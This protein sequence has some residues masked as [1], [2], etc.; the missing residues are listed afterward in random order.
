MF[1]F[2]CLTLFPPFFC[3]NAVVVMSRLLSLCS[4]RRS[5]GRLTRC[6]ECIDKECDDCGTEGMMEVRLAL[7]ISHAASFS[8]SRDSLDSLSQLNK[9]TKCDEEGGYDGDVKKMKSRALA[10]TSCLIRW[11]MD[12]FHSDLLQLLNNQSNIRYTQCSAV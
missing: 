8:S 2:D 6:V 4:Q 9:F 11:G 10:L 3:G 5:C 12:L 7:D 1:L